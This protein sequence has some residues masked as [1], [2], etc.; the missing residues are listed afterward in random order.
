MLV[1][2]LNVDHRNAVIPGMWRDTISTS[3][4]IPTYRSREQ[5]LRVH[6]APQS[7]SQRLL[8]LMLF[9]PAKGMRRGYS[10]KAKG[11]EWAL[12]NVNSLW[13]AVQGN[14]LVRKHLSVILGLREECRCLGGMRWRIF[15][16]E[17]MEISWNRD[18]MNLWTISL[19]VLCTSWSCR[20]VYRKG[21]YLIPR[22]QTT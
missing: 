7:V 20:A 17:G 11:Q 9:W 8:Y 3:S 1:T 19:R 5:C 4:P 21:T 15:R 22:D 18:S 10:E 14:S 13:E 16:F 2:S 6:L 12:R